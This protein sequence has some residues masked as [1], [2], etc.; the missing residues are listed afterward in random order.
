MKEMIPESS[1]ELL[2]TIG[3][4]ADK[5]GLKAWVVGGAVRD[6]Y[7]NKKTED[8]DLIFNGNQESVAGFCIRKWRGIKHR[9][10]QFGTF[11]VNLDNGLKLDLA[12]LRKEIYE[13]PGALPEVTFTTRLKDDLFRRD[14]TVNAWACSI[15]P[16]SFG[17]SCDSYGAQKDID[18]G[19]IRILHDKSFLEDPTRIFR[20]VRFAGRFGWK[21]APK[22]ERLLKEAVVEEYPLLLSRDR[23]SRELIK[24]LEEPKV[25]EIFGL[26]KKYDLL[27]FAWPGL[28][29]HPALGATTSLDLRIGVLVLSLGERSEDFMNTL[30]LPK[31]LTHE[32]HGARRLIQE[33]TAPLHALTSYQHSLIR[34]MCPKLPP[35]ALEPCFVRGGEIRESGISIH[36]I[37]GALTYIRKAQWEGKITNREAAFKWLSSL[38]KEQK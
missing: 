19:L 36:R 37:S 5:L 7:L 14:F 16:D 31:Q 29:Y 33:K 30:R 34:L 1:K 17:K 9:F 35:E 21:L 18:R 27:K 38:K 13:Y 8:I 23:F 4:Y 25:K 22:T 11:R 26:L 20:A 12:R 3:A 28:S 32:I 15:S 2:S 6:F 10:S 24:I